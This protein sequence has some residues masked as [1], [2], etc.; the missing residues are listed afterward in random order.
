[1]QFS[2]DHIIQILMWHF[3]NIVIQ[4]YSYSLSPPIVFVVRFSIHITLHK[5]LSIILL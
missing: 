1:M 3:L 4:H 2:S 5:Y